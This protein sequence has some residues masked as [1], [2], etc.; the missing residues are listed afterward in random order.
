[1]DKESIQ[2]IFKK[3]MPKVNLPQIKSLTLFLL[4]LLKSKKY[5]SSQNRSDNQS[6]TKHIP[7][8][9]G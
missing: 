3:A 4:A 9:K 2:K 5:E 1:M 7:N 8:T 6:T